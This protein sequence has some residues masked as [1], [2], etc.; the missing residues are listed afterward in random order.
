MKRFIASATFLLA[1]GIYAVFSRLSQGTA[2]DALP[3]SSPAVATTTSSAPSSV[4][5]DGN[6]S[7]APPDYPSSSVASVYTDI[8]SSTPITPVISSSSSVVSVSSSS[9]P[10]SN[11]LYRDGTYTGQSADAYY[12][13]VQVQVT[14]ANAQITDVRFLDYPSDRRTSEEINQQAMP[15]LRAEAIQT[16]SAPVDSVSGAT[17]TSQAFNE[18]FASAL[19]QAKN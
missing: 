15:Y 12:G 11:G 16:Q 1:F 17:Y 18:S 7:S 19:A 14:V 3:V 8:P 10:A 6:A 2:V 4:W 5:S 13:N 9:A